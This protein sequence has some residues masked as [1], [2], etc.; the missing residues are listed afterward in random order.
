MA[1][2]ELVGRIEYN[3]NDPDVPLIIIDGKPYTGEEVGKMMMSYEGF[4]FRL[5]IYDV[6][7]E[8]E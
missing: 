5:K 1:D 2:G 6:T 4:Q 3:E 7:D 8:I